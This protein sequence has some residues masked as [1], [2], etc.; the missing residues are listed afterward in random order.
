VKTSNELLVLVEI[1]L[2]RPDRENVM[3]ESRGKID[4]KQ[5][6]IVIV[7]LISEQTR[8]G[9]R[10]VIPE[11]AIFEFEIMVTSDGIKI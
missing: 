5:F 7:L 6:E 8:L 2:L 3:F 10:D 9:D 1:G 4:V 11:Q